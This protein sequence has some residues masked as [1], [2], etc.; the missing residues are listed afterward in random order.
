LD[1]EAALKKLADRLGIRDQV[2]VL[3]E[4][5]DVPDILAASDMF[6]LPSLYEGRPISV[7]EAMAAGAP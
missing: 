7:L 4:R 5:S 2:R 1:E 3:G 6:V